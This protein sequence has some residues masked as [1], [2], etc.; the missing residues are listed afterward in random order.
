MRNPFIYVAI[1]VAA[2]SPAAAQV[3]EK[4]AASARADV[5]GDGKDDDIR[6]ENGQVVVAIGG[7]KKQGWKAFTTPGIVSSA[8]I[9]IGGTGTPYIAVHAR[10]DLDG[11]KVHEGLV[12]R[13]TKGALAE[14]WRG[15]VGPVGRD[16]DYEIRIDATAKGLIRSQRRSGVVRCDGKPARLFSEGWDEANGEFRPIKADVS[17]DDSAPVLTASR[18]PPA[19]EA[20]ISAVFRAAAGSTEAGAGDASQLGTPHELDDGDPATVWREDRGGDGRGEFVTY[21][22][23]RGAKVKALRIVPGDG[24]S[25]KDMM[26]SN[27]L[28]RFAVVTADRAYWIEVPDGKPKADADAALPWWIVFDEP[29][30]AEC[31]TVVWSTFH[32]GKGAKAG[33]GTSAV[34]DLVVLAEED[35]VAGGADAALIEQVI[36][37]GIDGDSAT[38]LLAR[39][40]TIAARAIEKKLGEAGVPGDAKVRLWLVLAQIADAGSV[41]ELG[42]ALG[43]SGLRDRDATRI[44]DAL[45][46]LGEPG[47]DQLARVASDATL[48]EGVRIAAASRL[49]DGRRDALVAALGPGPRA[50]RKVIAGKLATAG[51][52]WLIAAATQAA[53]DGTAEREADLWRALGLA[54]LGASES[55]RNLAIGAL[56]GRAAEVTDYER[57]YRIAGAL[58]ALPDTAAVAATRTLLEGLGKGGEAA[59]I[60]QVAAAALAGSAT[61]DAPALLATLAKEDRDPGVRLAAV[62]GLAG[63]DDLAANGAWETGGGQ[64]LVDRV[65]QNALAGDRWP[66]V[67]RAAAS[68]LSLACTRPGPTAALEDAVARDEDVGVRGDALAALVACGAKGISDRV[69]AVARDGRA[70]TALRERAVELLASF[71][72]ADIA[73][74]LVTELERWRSAAFSEQSGLDLAQRA[75]VTLGTLGAAA[76]A[77]GDAKTTKAVRDAL[78]DAAGDPAFAEIQA[79]GAAGLGALGPACDGE[80]KKFLKEMARSDQASVKIAAGRALTTCGK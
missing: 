7:S 13:W 44:A 15:E 8:E 18:T 78:L 54:A 76:H 3:A 45:A 41:P 67:R 80:S 10:F 57:R 69:L 2:V 22:A 34:S 6:V 30:A 23:R 75:A 11:K 50:L 64:D 32:A 62:R 37:G 65:L 1:I 24:R 72:D 29:I 71:D 77:R 55:D 28:A 36:A 26:K 42:R 51:V 59:A 14:V 25:A 43:A 19:N 21:R 46:R 33:G 47:A 49:G 56:A 5:D 48:G 70:P 35:V 38:K 52:E 58:A 61:P 53:A 66:E 39:R 20:L 63:R 68:A 40:G 27:R 79:A 31:V 12:V 16:G 17:V 73:I 60:R 74:A 9:T 4:P